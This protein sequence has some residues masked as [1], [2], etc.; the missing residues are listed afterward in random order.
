MRTPAS[1]RSMV[2]AV[3]I[4]ALGCSPSPDED[5][6]SA[7][8]SQ[9]TS[10]PGAQVMATEAPWYSRARVL[11]LTDDGRPDGVRLEAFGSRPDS[12]HV[13]LTLVVD[14]EEKLRE[15]WGSSYE[16][17]LLDSAVRAGPE[18]G[19]ILRVKL[20]SVLASVEVERLDRPSEQLMMEDGPALDS[21]RVPPT[22]LVSFSYG[23]ETTTRLAWDAPSERFVRLWSC[24]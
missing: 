24:C 22:H 18:A 21:L 17:A 20:D 23:Y 12:L 11:D 8:P 6:S 9:A 16:L 1:R 14:G 10:A 13:V 5:A 4:L 19:G 3:G 15:E 2:L 7:A